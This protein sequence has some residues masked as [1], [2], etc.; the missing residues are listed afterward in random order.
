MIVKPPG[1]PAE[2]R[3]FSDAE[4]VEAEQY[5]EKMGATVEPLG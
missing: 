2:I 5:A 4:R 3:V 1:R